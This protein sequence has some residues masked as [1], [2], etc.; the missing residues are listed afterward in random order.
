MTWL[1]SLAGNWRAWAAVGVAVLG[2]AV[3]VQTVRLDGCKAELQGARAKL[4][5]L[6]A[7]I[8]AQN[9]AVAALELDGQRRTASAAL[10]AQAARKQAEGLRGQAQALERA[11]EVSRAHPERTQASACPAGDAVAEVRRALAR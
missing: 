6:G 11:L 2:L 7:Q 5:V 8:E 10:A 4:A 1:L 3:Y 9:A